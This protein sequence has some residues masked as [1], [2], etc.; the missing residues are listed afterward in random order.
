MF[1]VLCFFDSYNNSEKCSFKIV[2][3]SHIDGKSSEG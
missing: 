2:M 1:Y 3:I